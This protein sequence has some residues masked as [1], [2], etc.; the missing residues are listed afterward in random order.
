MN[1]KRFVVLAPLLLGGCAAGSYCEG[2][3]DYAEAA[4]VPVIQ[5]AEGLQLKESSTALKIPP[6]PETQVPYGEKVTDAKGKESVHC[7]DQ[8]PALVLPEPKPAEGAAPAEVPAGAP[9]A[10]PPP[11]TP[12]APGGS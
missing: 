1:L 9:P 5:S 6:V 7:L 12:P 8:P 11:A 3:Q 4:S 10:T 2:D